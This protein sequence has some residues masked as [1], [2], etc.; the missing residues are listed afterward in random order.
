MKKPPSKVA[1]NNSNPLLFSLLPELP[2]RPKQK[3]SCSKMWPIDQLYMELGLF[4]LA[5]IDLCC[6]WFFPDDILLLDQTAVKFF[7]SIRS[8]PKVIV[9]F[10]NYLIEQQSLNFSHIFCLNNNG[11]LLPKLFW[12]TVRKNCSSDRENFQKFWDH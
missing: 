6:F 3:N 4:H 8:Q 10:T 7:K 5:T 1:Q 2:K 12:P 11:I 9:Y